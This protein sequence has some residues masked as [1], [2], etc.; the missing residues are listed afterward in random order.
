MQILSNSISVLLGVVSFYAVILSF[1]YAAKEEKIFPLIKR[2]LQSLKSK[3]HKQNLEKQ[4][5]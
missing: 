1:E 3:S 5:V 4:E 2:V